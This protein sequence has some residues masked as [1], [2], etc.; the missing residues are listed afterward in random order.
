MIHR[1]CQG[2]VGGTLFLHL[3]EDLPSAL[4]HLDST[5]PDHRHALV[6]EK[7]SWMDQVYGAGEIRVGSMH[8]VFSSTHQ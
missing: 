4:P 5:D 2:C 6:V 7:G 8:L 1:L 3:P